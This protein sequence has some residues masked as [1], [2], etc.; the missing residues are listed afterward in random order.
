MFSDGGMWKRSDGMF[1]VVRENIEPTTSKKC[2]YFFAKAKAEAERLVKKEG[3]SFTV[4]EFVEK[5]KCSPVEAPIEWKMT[6]IITCL[7]AWQQK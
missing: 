2:H 5:G 1:V 6:K 3:V 7:E 4:Y